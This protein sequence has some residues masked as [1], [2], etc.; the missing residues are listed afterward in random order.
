M[1]KYSGT[2]FLFVFLFGFEPVTAQPLRYSTG[3]AH[4]HNDYLNS[5]PFF[6]AYSNGFGSMEADVFP[7]GEKL[8]VAHT[9]KEIDSLRTLDALYLQ[10]FM[11]LTELAHAMRPFVLLVDIK[12]DYRRA[13]ALLVKALEPLQQHLVQEGKRGLMKIVISGSRPLPDFKNYPGYIFFDDDLRQKHSTE[14][15]SRVALVSLP[16]NRISSWKGTGRMN[17][18]DKQKLRHI[19]DSVH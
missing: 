1:V 12:E 19:I 2:F 4:A 15:W 9:K 5:R 3:N 17:K 11:K 8:F 14:S 6:L 13:L 16:F 18:N 7:V 10:P